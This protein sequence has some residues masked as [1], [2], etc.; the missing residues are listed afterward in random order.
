MNDR[1]QDLRL[2][3]CT[4]RKSIKVFFFPSFLQLMPNC[5]L[6]LLGADL[7]HVLRT[8][9]GSVDFK[10][11]LRFVLADSNAA[12][13]ARNL[14]LL[15]LLLGDN[16]Y[17]KGSAVAFIRALYSLHLDQATFHAIRNAMNQILQGE[18]LSKSQNRFLKIVLYVWL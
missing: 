5:S 4:N 16:G 14:V 15:R 10:G 8:V 18:R 9:A 13:Q 3:S 17:N 7:K 2:R 12:I 1:K 11:S 6:L